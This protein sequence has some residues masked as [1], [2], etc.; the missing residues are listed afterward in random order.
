MTYV[1]TFLWISLLVYG[2]VMQLTRVQKNSKR[3]VLFKISLTI[4][5]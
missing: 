5:N 2:L 4:A 1:E 3:A